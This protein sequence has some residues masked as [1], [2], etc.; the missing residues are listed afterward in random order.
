MFLAKGTEPEDSKLVSRAPECTRPLYLSNTDNKIISIAINRPFKLLC[1]T[2]VATEQRGFVVGRD[3][4]SN[5]VD[6]ESRALS[7]WCQQGCD[8]AGMAFLDI[9]AAFPS[10]YHAM[11]WWVLVQMQIPA[12]IIDALKALYKGM[13]VQ[14]QFCARGTAAIGPR[15]V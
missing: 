8:E 2:T 11:I 6:I 3:L 14:I 9:R 13:W 1:Q 10:L 15:G 12:Y 7:W 5:V 4:I